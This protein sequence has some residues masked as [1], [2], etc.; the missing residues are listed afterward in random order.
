LFHFAIERLNNDV[1]EE[2]IRDDHLIICSIK[3]DAKVNSADFGL[4][5]NDIN[6][7]VISFKAMTMLRIDQR[8]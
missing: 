8:L 3:V 2:C 1:V 6:S 5:E 4:V 7:L